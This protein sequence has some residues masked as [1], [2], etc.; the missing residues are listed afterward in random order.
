MTT[1]YLYRSLIV[2]ETEKA[3]LVRFPKKSE[4]NYMGTWIP[5]KRVT[6]IKNEDEE[7]F[8]KLEVK[9]FYTYGLH[10]LNNS[11]ESTLL[12]R[13]EQFIELFKGVDSYARKE[14]DIQAI[15]EQ[16]E[17]DFISLKAIRELIF[18]NNFDSAKLARDTGISRQTLISLH[19]KERPLSNV[20][21]ETLIKM[22]KYI[23]SK[24]RK[25]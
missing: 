22:Q 11:H 2:R 21:L 18:D 4:Y 7:E 16:E 15:E 6:V 23:Y 25:E 1:L 12:I 8:Y 24:G 17:L 19:K 14:L 20:K 5:K 3:I 10:S 13:A 9:P